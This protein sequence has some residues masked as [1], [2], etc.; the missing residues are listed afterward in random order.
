V[1]LFLLAP[2]VVL[3]LW[4][5]LFVISLAVLIA[6]GFR[7]IFSFAGVAVLGLLL[8]LGLLWYA[9]AHPQP[10]AI[11]G[12]VARAGQ[13]SSPLAE[14]NSLA[15]PARPSAPPEKA[16][17]DSLAAGAPAGSSSAKKPA[18]AASASRPA[19]VD[20]QTGV[21]DGIYRAMVTVGPYKTWEECQ[22]ELDAK[23]REPVDEYVD[24]RF[25][26]GAAERLR[27]SP[28]FIRRNLKKAEWVEHRVSP[29][30]AIG[31]MVQYY[32]R[33]D[34]DQPATGQLEDQWRRVQVADRIHTGGVGVAAL[35][36]VL[37]VAYVYLKADIATQGTRR[38]RLR[39]S[40]AVALA[41]IVAAVRLLVSRPW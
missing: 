32:V 16:R 6:V 30:P 10:Q 18:G 25:G 9:A 2:L 36:L 17:A 39:L 27:V 13:D 20:Q 33:L 14:G 7:I 26:P 4:V 31:P 23:L 1:A 37:S 29:T 40:A 15:D 21:V 24:R 34:F 22:H 28:D 38:G 35:L 3:M 19:W 11:P 8:V 41:G 5:T 12:Y